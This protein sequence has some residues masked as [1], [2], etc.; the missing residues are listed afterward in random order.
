MIDLAK[1]EHAGRERPAMLVVYYI[2]VRHGQNSV[3]LR[4]LFVFDKIL[5]RDDG[6][7]WLEKKK[8]KRAQV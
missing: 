7:R 4:I 5:T 3:W 2:S 1:E 8:L 6:I